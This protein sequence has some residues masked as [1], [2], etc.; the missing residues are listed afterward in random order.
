VRLS[1]VKLRLYTLFV[2]LH[3]EPLQIPTAL[4]HFLYIFC[5]T[6]APLIRRWVGIIHTE[7]M[8]PPVYAPEKLQRR[9]HADKCC[10]CE[11]KK[12]GDVVTC[13]WTHREASAHPRKFQT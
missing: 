6:N 8:T 13:Y 9:T 1:V 11:I 12:A 2:I 3:P 4:N 10:T 5:Y 7:W